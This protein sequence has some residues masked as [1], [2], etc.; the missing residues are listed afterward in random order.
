MNNMF[1]SQPLTILS[2]DDNDAIRY[3]FARYLREGGYDVIEAR[4]GPVIR[5]PKAG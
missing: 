4:T 2:V 5:C 3:S 1:E